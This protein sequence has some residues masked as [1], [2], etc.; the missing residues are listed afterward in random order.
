[1]NENQYLDF[2]AKVAK[3]QKLLFFF[4]KIREKLFTFFFFYFDNFFNKN[5]NFANSKLV[6]ME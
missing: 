3:A 6:G 2:G 5:N 4:G 1:M